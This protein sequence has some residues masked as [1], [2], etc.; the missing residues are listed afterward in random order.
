MTLIFEEILL[1]M[2][3]DEAISYSE[4][5]FLNQVAAQCSF[6]HRHVQNMIAWAN[7]GVKWKNDKNGLMA[8]VA[9]KAQPKPKAAGTTVSKENSSLVPRRVHCFVCNSNQ[10][11][12]YLQLK[13]NS[14][15]PSRNI[16]GL[17]TYK[18]ANKGFDFIDYNR[19]TPIVCPQCYFTSTDKFNFKRA[20]GDKAP[21][22]LMNPKF[23][24]PWVQDRRKFE[25]QLGQ[26]LDEIQSINR[27]D[28]TVEATYRMA[29]EAERRL[30]GVTQ[31]PKHRWE[32]IVNLLTLAEIQITQG[33]Q[34]AAEESLKAAIV[35]AKEV[36]LVR[37]NLMVYKAGRMLFLLGLYFGD[38]DLSGTYY[39]FLLNV[40]SKPDE[41][42]DEEKKIL[43]KI[44]G[45]AKK[46]FE[47]RAEYAK[48]ALDGFHLKEAPP[49]AKK[50]EQAAEAAPAK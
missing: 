19:V 29:I 16:F 11:G 36:F 3:T 6:D 12:L 23:A 47:N 40:S 14:Q 7:A 49:K 10:P 26:A 31:D 28:A 43:M 39:N 35:E 45:E 22:E 42:K 44:M 27:G 38:K 37:D 34:A 8:K 32:W 25:D 15:K 17:P 30:W 50:G 21:M 13:P 2:S 18:E 46:A 5:T 20:E 41:L 1:L 48:A 24:Q 33:Q 4:Q 9:I